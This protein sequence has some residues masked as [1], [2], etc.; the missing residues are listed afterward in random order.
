MQKQ[1]VLAALFATAQAADCVD[2]NTT[3]AKGALT[4]NNNATAALTAAK[5][6]AEGAAKVSQAAWDKAVLDQGTWTTAMSAFVGEQLLAT[7][8][9][10]AQKKIMDDAKVAMD[11]LK[12]VG[13]GAVDIAANKLLPLWL[14]ENAKSL[15]ATA[16][17]ATGAGSLW[18]ADDDAKTTLDVLTVN[19]KEHNDAKTAAKKA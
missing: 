10:N 1:L 7:N 14:A 9:F 13:V 16:V 3:M 5:L 4:A 6:T 2:S 19:D 18:K 17:S 8:E 12:N 15:A 11:A